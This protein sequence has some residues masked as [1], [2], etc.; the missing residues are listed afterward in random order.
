[1]LGAGGSPRGRGGWRDDGGL[2]GGI[3]HGFWLF[4]R[5]G[6]PR[7]NHVGPPRRPEHETRVHGGEHAEHDD[8]DHPRRRPDVVL[9]QAVLDRID[10]TVSPGTTINPAYNS[11]ANP[12]LAPAAR[13]R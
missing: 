2:V 3:A 5:G 1:M 8:R 4:L 9:D 6:G 7:G 10:Q 11:W 12:A 13:R